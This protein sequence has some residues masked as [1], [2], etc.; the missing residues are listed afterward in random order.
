M[1]SKSKAC[2]EWNLPEIQ[3]E[4]VKLYLDI[5]TVLHAKLYKNCLP[6]VIPPSCCMLRTENHLKETN[7]LDSVLTR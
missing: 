4:R 2:A 5:L 1:K 3:F 6:L 7:Q